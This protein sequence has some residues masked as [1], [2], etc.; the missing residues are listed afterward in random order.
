MMWVV[1]KLAWKLIMCL[2]SKETIV[3]FV[4]LKKEEEDD[5]DDD[6]D[7]DEAEDK[8]NKSEDSSSES[9]S[10]GSSDSES[11]WG[12]ASRRTEQRWAEP[13]VKG[14]L[15]LCQPCSPPT[16]RG[17][18]CPATSTTLSLIV[19]R[20]RQSVFFSWRGGPS[21][22]SENKNLS[23]F[24]PWYD[25]HLT[26]GAANVA[27]KTKIPS[28]PLVWWCHEHL[29][30]LFRSCPAGLMVLMWRETLRCLC[31]YDWL[32]FE[33]KWLHRA[34]EHNMVDHVKEGGGGGV[35]G[36]EKKK[37]H[38]SECFHYFICFVLFF[39]FL[40]RTFFF[41]PRSR[42][43]ISDVDFIIRFLKRWYFFQDKRWKT[44]HYECVSVAGNVSELV[45][46]PLFFLFLFDFSIFLK[47]NSAC[48]KFSP[49]LGLHFHVWLLIKLNPSGRQEAV[50]HCKL[51]TS[52]I[53]RCYVV[54]CCYV[55]LKQNI[56]LP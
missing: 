10:Q 21:L 17:S 33:D 16:T 19:C 53:R 22:V 42:L 56:S 43:S 54:L 28:I 36:T 51:G 40:S 45:T 26:A 8:E 7:D 11:D 3:F 55:L 49:L 35:Q 47:D 31:F 48:T 34:K 52:W 39:F 38:S 18:L 1:R 41:S 5:D 23:S 6:D 14:A 30:L 29:C 50:T 15:P 46:N 20:W 13:R 2:V 9:N 32:L 37:L 44:S 12:V 4:C 27:P 25:G 24:P